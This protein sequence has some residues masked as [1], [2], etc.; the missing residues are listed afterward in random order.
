MRVSA[1]LALGVVSGLALS[2]ASCGA[3]PKPCGPATC[4]GCCDSNGECLG[5]SAVFECGSGGAM[6]Q[7]CQPNELCRAGACERFDGGAYDATFPEARDAAIN[8]DAGLFDA[9]P[10]IDAGVD[11]G[12][13]DAGV[14]DAGRPDAGSPVDAGAVD[15]GRPVSFMNDL[16]PIFTMYCTSCHTNRATY[17]DVRARVVPGSP[18]SS[19]LYQKITG[20]QTVGA[21]M[22][23]GG[24][25]SVD[26]APATALIETWIRQGALNN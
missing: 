6:C 5:G 18:L 14:A 2:L 4:S 3:P 8:F 26:D 22:P 9:G 19:L 7:A 23:L 24:Q 17:A 12:R 10:M 16:V 21:P 1:A 13:V 20:T 25:L 15:A 11:A